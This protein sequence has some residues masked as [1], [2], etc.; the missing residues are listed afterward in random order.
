MVHTRGFGVH[1]YFETDDSLSEITMVHLFQKKR[2]ENPW[3]RAI[4]DTRWKPGVS[5]FSSRR[6]RLCR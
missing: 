2:R 5:R 3:F 1:G 4:F 6:A